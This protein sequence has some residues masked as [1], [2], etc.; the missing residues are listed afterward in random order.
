MARK[1]QKPPNVN[2]H[3]IRIARDDRHRAAPA[4]GWHLT[5]LNSAGRL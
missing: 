2:S 1:I 5:K 3:G 4:G